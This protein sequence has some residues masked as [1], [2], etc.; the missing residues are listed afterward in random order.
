MNFKTLIVMIGLVGL[1]TGPAF[2]GQVTFDFVD[3]AAVLGEHGTADPGETFTDLSGLSVTASGRSLDGLT[4]YFMYLDGLLGGNASKPGGLGVCQSLNCAGSSDDN[5]TI[6]EVLVLK[7]DRLVTIDEITF[8]NGIHVDVY[9]GNFGLAIDP[10]TLPTLATDF[11]EYLLTAVFTPGVPLNGMEFSFI[12]PST[13]L[14]EDS[15]DLRRLYISSI[16]VTA[17]PEPSSLFLLGFGLLAGGVTF[18]KS[19]K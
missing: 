7:F 5:L 14:D 19:F 13:V 10:S 1:V 9:D 8:S 16:T 15:S 6:G 3:L 4:P 17:V 18:R 11:D 2:A 12:A